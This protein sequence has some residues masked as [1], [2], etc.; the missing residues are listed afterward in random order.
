[1]IL[2]IVHPNGRQELHDHV[3]SLYLTPSKA[4]KEG[5][6]ENGGRP[7]YISQDKIDHCN[8]TGEPIPCTRIDYTTNEDHGHSI[9]LSYDFQIYVMSDDGKTVDRW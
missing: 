8:E 9:D 3:T 6:K 4:T 2:K 1:M 7:H 5:I